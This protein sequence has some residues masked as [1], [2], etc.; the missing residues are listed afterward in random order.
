VAGPALQFF[1]SFPPVTRWILAALAGGTLLI[2]LTLRLLP[3]IGLPSPVFLMGVGEWTLREGWWWQ[4][5]TYW[6]SATMPV[7]FGLGM[8]LYA[9]LDLFF[10][11]Q[12]LGGLE[13]RLGSRSSFALWMGGCLTGGVVGA[14]VLHHDWVAPNQ[15]LLGD[16]AGLAALLVAWMMAFGEEMIWLFVAPLPSK[17]L[18]VGLLAIEWLQLLSSGNW[19]TLAA[20]GSAALFAF[21]YAVI[22]WNLQAPFPALRLA[23][24]PLRWISAGL[25]RLANRWSGRERAAHAVIIDFRTGEEIRR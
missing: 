16:R 3:S 5:G 7:Q 18:A 12:F 2:S 21:V 4:I 10:I 11:A 6:M 14:L 13:R 20:S 25:R 17:W 23:E 8:I 1:R 15:I 22:A 19:V 9:V 24:R